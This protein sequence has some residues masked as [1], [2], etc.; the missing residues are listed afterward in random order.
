MSQQ[1]RIPSQL[2]KPGDGTPP[3]CFAGR[4]DD[5]RA[6]RSYAEGLD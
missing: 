5:E 1:T 4:E 3:P 6:L 2:F